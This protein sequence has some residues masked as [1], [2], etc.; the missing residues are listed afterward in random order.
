[1]FIGNKV[2]YKTRYPQNQESFGAKVS[3]LFL[4]NFKVLFHYFIYTKIMD[5]INQYQNIKNKPKIR[6]YF[7]NQN[8]E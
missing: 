2:S 6:I 1:M 4:I 3:G 8:P 5:L 7:T